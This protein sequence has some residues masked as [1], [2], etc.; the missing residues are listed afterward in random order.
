MMNSPYDPTRQNPADEEE[1][2]IPRHKLVA[3]IML[4]CVAAMLF[5]IFAL[6]WLT[7]YAADGR[8]VE[9][10][11]AQ[12]LMD[13]DEQELQDIQWIM[14]FA[15]YAGLDASVRLAMKNPPRIWHTLLTIIIGINSF[16]FFYQYLDYVG[17]F[18]NIEIA[19]GAVIT[20]TAN[21]FIILAAASEFMR[22]GGPSIFQV[23]VQEQNT[24]SSRSN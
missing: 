5:G 7:L 3:I 16:V 18:A 15:F 21:I 2:P 14:V 1:Q 17:Q 22:P 6:D 11:S 9:T 8:V 23:D 24:S 10:L 4:S 13:N 20:A 19:T 12:D